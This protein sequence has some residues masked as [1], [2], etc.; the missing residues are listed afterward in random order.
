MAVSLVT[1]GSGFIGLHLVNLLLEK[2]HN[3][4]TTVRSFKDIAKCQPLLDLQSKYPGKLSIFEANLMKDGSFTQAMQGCTVIYHVASPFLVPQQI[5]DGVKDCVEPALQ[6]T[7]NV[8]ESVNHCDSVHRVVLTSSIAA[9][10]G[11]CIKVASQK[12]STLTESSWNGTSSATNNP[13]HYSKVIAEREA[14]KMQQAQNRWDLVVINPGLV[15]GPSLSPESSSGSLFMVESMY[16]GDNKMGCPEL[17]FPIVDVRDVAEAHVRAG[18]NPAA[19]G[20]YIVAGAQ[21]I[22]L[23]EMAYLVRPIHRNPKVLPRRNLPKLLVYA[24]GPFI[25][26]SMKRIA[27]NIGV[28][29]NVDNSRSVRELGM[30]YRVADEVIK[31]HYEAWLKNKEGR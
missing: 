27:G 19:K 2:G 28:R 15:L 9:M 8:L 10:Y 30:S 14:W 17:Y 6:G 5:K 23:L 13:Y 1:G 25:G 18:A 26:V 7:R 3:V 12:N 20:R 11:D 4:H 31:D 29:F 16:R 24:I 21:A 22:G